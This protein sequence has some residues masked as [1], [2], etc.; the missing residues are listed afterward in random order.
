MTEIQPG[1]R[2]RRESPTTGEEVALLV[3]YG[4]VPESQAVEAV[5]ASGAVVEDRLLY[6]TLAVRIDEADLDALCSVESVA[7][8]EIEGTWEPMDEGNSN[9]RR[10][11][12]P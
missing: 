8:V 6:D 4:D 11:S 2:R 10:G 5:E 1:V 9:S 12:N 3:G 7:T